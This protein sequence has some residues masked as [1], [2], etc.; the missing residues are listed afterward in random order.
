MLR[1]GLSMQKG[2]GKEWNDVLGI[3][4][5]Y[6]VCFAYTYVWRKYARRYG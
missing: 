1:T 2:I 4:I 5:M 3:K 6:F